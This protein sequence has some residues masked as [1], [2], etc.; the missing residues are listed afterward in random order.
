MEVNPLQEIFKRIG[1]TPTE[2]L[3]NGVLVKKDIPD[4]QTEIEEYAGSTVNMLRN[5]PHA[6]ALN[7]KISE[8]GW[9]ISTALEL[10]ILLD[11]LPMKEKE[12]KE[13]IGMVSR[14]SL[15]VYQGKAGPNPGRPA[16]YDVTSIPRQYKRVKLVGVWLGHNKDGEDGYKWTASDEA[17]NL[18]EIHERHEFE[19]SEFTRKFDQQTK[20]GEPQKVSI[21]NQKPKCRDHHDKSEEN[22]TKGVVKWKDEE[23]KRILDSDEIEDVDNDES[24]DVHID[25]EQKRILDNDDE[26]N[27]ESDDVDSDQE[28]AAKR[29]CTRHVDD[30]VAALV[31]PSAVVVVPQSLVS[32][33]TWAFLNF[34]DGMRV[35]VTTNTFRIG[36]DGSKNEHSFDNADTTTQ[37]RVSR[38][39][40]SIS[41]PDGKGHAILFDKSSNGTWI[42]DIRIQTNTN[43]ELCDGA[44]VHLHKRD[45]VVPSLGTSFTFELNIS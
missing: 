20:I 39:H 43:T 38:N 45:G 26:D 15:K 32:P 6:E 19:I 34:H 31:P 29:L 21:V 18:E 2:V 1:V 35:P 16:T 14:R 9:K 22:N 8:R 24:D 27:D 7:K 13:S 10:E 12:R 5:C 41:K 3:E 4:S 17:E 44:I 40:C 42:G 33:D 11:L 36:R 30:A 37:Q 28:H 23:G 25:E